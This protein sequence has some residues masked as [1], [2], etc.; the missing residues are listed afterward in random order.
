MQALREETSKDIK[1]RT[2]NKSK[3]YFHGSGVTWLKA[4]IEEKADGQDFPGS[5]LIEPGKIANFQIDKFSFN[6]GIPEVH[7]FVTTKLEKVLKSNTT[8]ISIDG[9]N[10]P[11]E[12]SK[13]Q[14]NDPD[15]IQGSFHVTFIRTPTLE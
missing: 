5:E 2:A 8:I 12:D 4:T 1:V 3:T 14:S 6:T 11:K 9:F 7:D 13:Y 15:V 10:A